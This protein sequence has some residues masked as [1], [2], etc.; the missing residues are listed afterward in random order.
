MM[1]VIGSRD[2]LLGDNLAF[3]QVA[4]AAGA[5]VQVEVFEGMWH[6]FQEESAGCGAHGQLDEGLTAVKRVGEFFSSGGNG[7][8]V[9]CARGERCS[10]T[11]PVNW[12]Y[13]VNRLPMAT[14][15]DCGY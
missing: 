10:G 1:L 13:H 8:K 5:A 14:E 7:C 3:A 6:D 9:V 11:A 2:V 12:H 4:Q 15:H